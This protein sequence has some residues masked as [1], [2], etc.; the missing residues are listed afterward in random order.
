M[1]VNAVTLNPP[2]HNDEI[3]LIADIGATSTRC[4]TL[5]GPG[6]VLGEFEVF[7]NDAFASPLALIESYLAADNPVPQRCALAIAAPI[8]GDDIEMINRDWSFN[9]VELS[10]E[11][12]VDQLMVFNDFH[13]NALSLPSVDD[14]L[15]VEIGSAIEYSDG[16]I[17]VLGPGTGLGMAAWIGN[18]ES[19]N[20][21][22]GEGGHITVSG[23][24]TTE[25]K[26]I[27]TLRERFGHCSA[28]RI[29]SGPG[30]VALHNAMHG[31]DVATA[32]TITKRLDD[33]N[34]A[35]TMAQFYRFLGSAAA[36]LALITGAFGGVYVA[37]G[38]V[39]ANIEGI[40][41]SQF[42]QRFEDKGR[43]REY[44]QHIPTYVI[45]DPVPGLRGLACYVAGQY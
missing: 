39:P 35:A 43:Y 20:V 13:A 19:G 44:M 36:D 29:L 21:M 16:N 10:A 38:I 23:R 37:G 22:F 7:A 2:S 12:K 17:A 3:W 31:I 28:E 34:C 30:L 14:S 40:S 1:L 33:A 8:R 41:N 9:R 26:I 32:E 6:F 42:R 18:K 11:L 4:A 45:T 25:D 15:R 5:Q 24:D 27:H